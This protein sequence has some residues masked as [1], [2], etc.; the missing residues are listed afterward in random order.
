M[1]F[2]RWASFIVRSGTSTIGAAALKR[3]AFAGRTS[4]VVHPSP[5]AAQVKTTT[6][7]IVAHGKA[8]RHVSRDGMIR[9]LI[10]YF[11]MESL[12]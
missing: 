2:R 9:A 1:D 3:D 10:N 5:R 11:N 12:P 8:I 7:S 4:G 6:V